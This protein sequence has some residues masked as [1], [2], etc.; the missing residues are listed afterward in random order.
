MTLQWAFT[1]NL[2]K[3][4]IALAINVLPLPQY[5]HSDPLLIVVGREKRRA[6][7]TASMCIR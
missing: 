1:N 3:S 5:I 4:S 6:E 2:A 7:S